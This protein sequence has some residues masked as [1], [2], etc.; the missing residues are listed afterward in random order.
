MHYSARSD[1][2]VWEKE[3]SFEIKGSS[4]MLQSLAEQL[5]HCSSVADK[6]ILLA[7][8]IPVEQFLQE[9]PALKVFIAKASPEQELVIK[10]A[11]AAGQ[12]ER[13]FPEFSEPKVSQIIERHLPRRLLIIKYKKRR[14]HRDFC[15]LCTET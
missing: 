1:I 13:L 6:N 8:F 5:A 11:L 10:A 7:G 9:A 14:F 2:S 12:G 15:V 4:N 3:T